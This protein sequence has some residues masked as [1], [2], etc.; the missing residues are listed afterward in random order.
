MM[1]A[2]LDLALRPLRFAARLAEN[3]LMAPL[4]A[5][6]HEVLD[7]VNAIQRATVSIE[8]HVEVIEGL[9]TSVGP[10]TDSVN[11]LTGTMRDLVTMLAPMAAV[12]HG[13]KQAGHEVE[14][15]E[16]FFR[17][18]RHKNPDGGAG[19]HAGS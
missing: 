8:H 2:I 16:R 18:H 19:D 9:A 10:L 14:R 5:T 7:A 1:L 13:V 17:L 6:E 15:A 12:E 11:Q 4:E 3:E